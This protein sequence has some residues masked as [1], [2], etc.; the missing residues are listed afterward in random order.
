L[1]DIE[2]LEET[3]QTLRQS[4]KQLAKQSA[5]QMEQMEQMKQQINMLLAAASQ[6]ERMNYLNVADATEHS[7]P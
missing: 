4:A 2:L 1:R 7:D 3:A 6:N 5:K